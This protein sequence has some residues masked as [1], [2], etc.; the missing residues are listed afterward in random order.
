[1]VSC[2]LSSAEHSKKPVDQQSLDY[3]FLGNLTH[4]NA[5]REGCN[6]VYMC[7][8]SS[9]SRAGWHENKSQSKINS[10]SKLRHELINITCS[11]SHCCPMGV[12]FHQR[13]GTVRGLK[14]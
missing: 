1:M 3:Y 8:F 5:P 12:S 9:M 4:P 6:D 2:S 14:R 13:D 10:A 11:L 7:Y